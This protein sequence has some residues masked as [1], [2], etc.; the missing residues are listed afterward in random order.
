MNARPP[1]AEADVFWTR[2]NMPATLETSARLVHSD[3][4]SPDGSRSACTGKLRHGRRNPSERRWGVC[5]HW[6]CTTCGAKIV[7]DRWTGLVN[8]DLSRRETW[9]E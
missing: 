7:L 5:H 3:L 8:L 2:S 4:A 9:H 1:Q 6:Q